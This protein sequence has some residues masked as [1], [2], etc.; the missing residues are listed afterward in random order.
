MP[1]K[2]NKPVWETAQGILK[3]KKS[4]EKAIVLGIF[5]MVTGAPIWETGQ[6]LNSPPTALT[7]LLLFFG[8]VISFFVGIVD[9]LGLE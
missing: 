3:G 6:L 4:P 5:L 2:R 8:G 1:K 9:Y 7:G